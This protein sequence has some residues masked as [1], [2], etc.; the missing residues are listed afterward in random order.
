MTSASQT[1]AS[2]QPLSQTA[3]ARKSRTGM[4]GITA[5]QN[6]VLGT[7]TTHESGYLATMNAMATLMTIR[8]I[9][10]MPETVARTRPEGRR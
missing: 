6:S 2:I 3:R 5:S 7:V 8:T 4:P 1:S 9:R 10:S